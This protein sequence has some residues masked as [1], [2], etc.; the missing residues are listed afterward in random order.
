MNQYQ[1]LLVIDVETA[2]HNLPALLG[3]LGCLNTSNE[4]KIQP[5]NIRNMD[6]HTE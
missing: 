2:A 3:L 5:P 4:M 6:E 1:Y